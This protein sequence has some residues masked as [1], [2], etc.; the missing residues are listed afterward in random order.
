MRRLPLSVIL[1]AVLASLWSCREERHSFVPNVGDAVPSMATTDVSTFISDSGYTRYHIVT[2][3]WLMFED[4]KDPYWRFPDGL[5]MEQYDENLR[6]NANIRCDSAK[7]LSRRRLWQLDGNVVMV[8]TQRDSFLT[9]QLFWDQQK[10]LVYSDSFI[11]IVRAD[12]IIEGYGFESDQN[13]LAY[14][15][16]RPTGIFAATASQ[17]APEPVTTEERDDSAD[18]SPYY[19][20][21]PAGRRRAPMRASERNRMAEESANHIIQSR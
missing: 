6:P 15:V 17:G 21:E 9:Q 16:N 14:T 18:V 2:P 10:R 11:H 5:Q 1:I 19:Y 4:V 12:R 8:N 3:L 7:Y 13:M 20:E